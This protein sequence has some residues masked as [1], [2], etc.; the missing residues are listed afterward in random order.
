[1]SVSEVNF[2]ERGLTGAEGGPST[3]LLLVLIIGDVI[4][5]INSW[6]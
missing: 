4:L 1:M 2:T 3:S 5:G 6:Y